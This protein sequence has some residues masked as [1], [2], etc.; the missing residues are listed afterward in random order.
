MGALAWWTKVPPDARIPCWLVEFCC[1]YSD[2]TGATLAGTEG[3]RCKYYTGGRG[4]TPILEFG[5]KILYMPSQASERRKVGAAIPLRS[6]CWYAELV[7]RGSGCH[8]AGTGDQDKVG[9]HQESTRVGE[10][11]T[12]TVYSKYGPLLGPQTAVTM[13]STSKLEWRDPLRW[14][15]RDPGESA[16]GE[17]SSEDL[18]SQSR[19]R[20]VGSRRRLSRVSVSQNWPGETTSAQ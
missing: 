5:E 3:Q 19:L 10:M 8:R 6:V 4:I 2:A 16:G 17:Q 15:P 7:V 11:E 12:L 20:A 14:C 18:P 13:R 1:M 9:E